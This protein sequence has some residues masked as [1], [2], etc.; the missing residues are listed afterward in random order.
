VT[1]ESLR[2]VYGDTSPVKTYRGFD[3]RPVRYYRT[4]NGQTLNEL[5]YQFGPWLV[6]VFDYTDVNQSQFADAMTDHER[7]VFARS[8]EGHVDANGYLVLR[9][10]SPLR[11][12]V[13]TDDLLGD[14]EPQTLDVELFAN[15][16]SMRDPATVEAHHAFGGG[17]PGISWCD[18]AT[19][20]QVS[21]TGPHD[22]VAAASANL[23]IRPAERVRPGVAV[24]F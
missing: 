12:L 23:R 7:A 14:G 2:D 4:P 3:G 22:V 10:R 20:F 19:G 24:G 1:Y 9:A 17:A 11:D 6:Q 13:S 18:R 21:L 8:L 5:V 16:C 15:R